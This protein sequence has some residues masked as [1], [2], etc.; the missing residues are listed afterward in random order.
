M[1]LSADFVPK[2]RQRNRDNV[3]DKCFGS[4]GDNIFMKEVFFTFRRSLFV[5]ILI[6]AIC[7]ANLLA[8]ETPFKVGIYHNPPVVSLD[9]K[10]TPQG[11]YVDTLNAI[12]ARENWSLDYVF[13]PWSELLEK[14]RAGEI[15][16]LTAVAYS[17]DRDIWLDFSREAFAQRW[18]VV[19][20]PEG[21]AVSSMMDLAG[22]RVALA[23]QD[24]HAGHFKKATDALGL[25]VLALE[26]EGYEGVFQALKNHKAD[27]GVVSNGYGSS[28]NINF[29]LTETSLVFKPTQLVIA[30]PQG[31]HPN[32]ADTIDAYLK[33]WKIDADS[34]FAVASR[35]LPGKPSGQKAPLALT[36]RQHDW[37]AAHPTVRVAFDGYFPPYSYLTDEGRIEGLS[38]EVLKLLTDR[39]DIHLDVYP[40]YVWKDLFDKAVGKEV[41]MVATMVHRPEREQWFSFTQPYIYKSMA[42]M[43]RDDDESI[44]QRE[45][46]AGKRV[47]LVR[48]YQYVERI[49][50]DFPTI[51]PYYVDT[52]LDG[53]N[54]VAADNADAVV[55]FFGAGSY[56]KTK[57]GITNLKFAAVYDRSSSFES[58]A[59]RKDW[60]ELVAILDKALATID[61]SELQA[62]KQKWN[63]DEALLAFFQESRLSNQRM[64]WIITM[65]AIAALA[66]VAF[67]FV[68]VWNRTL[69]RQVNSKT[70]A[71]EEELV[72]S[73]RMAS[74]LQENEEH[75]QS[76]FRAVPTGIG[77]S[78]GRVFKEVNERLC[79]ITGYSQEEL[80]GKNS[81]MLYLSTGDYD[82]VGLDKHEKNLE[83]GTVETRWT[84]KD[85][86]TI[87]V[88]LSF[89]PL[90]FNDRSKGVTFTA[91]DITERKEAEEALKVSHERFLTVL[92]SIDATIYVADMETHEILFM[93]KN[94]VEIF[95]GDLTG[96]VCWK[97]F[98]GNSGP[99]PH[100]TNHKLLDENQNPAGVSIWQDKNP[101]TGKWYINHDRAIVWTDGRLVK[102]QIATDITNIKKMEQQLQQAQKFEAIGTLAGGIAHDFNNLLMGIQGRASL[103]SMDLEPSHGH[104][105]HIHAVEGY[106][107]SATDLTKQL[108]G[109]ARGGKY[110]VKP[111]DINALVSHSAN[112]F[113]RTKK[114]IRIHTKLQ[115]PPLAVEV[116]PSQIEQVL[117][118]LYV[119]AWQAMPHGGELYL[120]TKIITMEEAEARAYGV[121]QGPYVVV[122]VMDTGIGMDEKT[123]QRIFDPFFTTKEK[124]R[125]TGLGLAS[126]YGIIK[127]HDGL[128]TTSSEVGHGTTFNIHL[129]LSEK[130]AFQE[131]PLEERLVKG[132]ETVLLVDDEEM[133]IEVGRAML[134]KLGYRVIIGEG[135]AQAVNTVKQRG[136]EIDL[137]IL[138]L[139]M[140]VM[141]GGK[142][143][144]CIREIQPHIPVMLSS[145]YA[146]DGQADEIM[147][148]G[149]DGFIQKPFNI[150]QLS[151]KIRGIFN[152]A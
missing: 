86:R 63:A 84:R 128:I 137:V 82:Y 50:K 49:I 73:S 34:V 96:E 101:A 147:K 95:G 40:A 28:N 93:N 6:C 116:D 38:V 33:K 100:C 12:A 30:F 121:R 20:V 122:S 3:M 113:G 57:Y 54:A 102:L 42:I 16:M 135:G 45:D 91:L 18:G 83:T 10:G 47:A 123:R 133:I 77:I 140:P 88:L 64:H 8:A 51:K 58:I 60:P 143:F 80:T 131:K 23:R 1:Q 104:T 119:N 19:Y 149:C 59:V 118:N 46:I 69:R 81:R 124:G 61:Q 5:A 78:I 141:D 89:T 99:C 31:K 103:M 2:A 98:R 105:E 17:P 71:L 150:S 148:R 112:M 66:V 138:D 65:A 132:S 75:L 134:E 125:G 52:M 39:L 35:Y 7:D 53:L 127:N 152:S 32:L 85:G 79:N 55:T 27:A 130:A 120:E 151:Q 139:V 142:V 68:Y 9:E 97:V 44:K 115:T 126:A 11:I 110:E 21:A 29:R 90:D 145:G 114:E 25:E 67:F 36:S 76:L 70:R 56:L 4:I 41:D 24:I 129:P 92:D 106:I 22:K 146:M 72:E 14:L 111:T 43:N 15:D 74:A 108:L 144:D 87:D 109:F 62:L 48:G 13:A 107:R 37:L 117:L 26:V 136:A 94:M